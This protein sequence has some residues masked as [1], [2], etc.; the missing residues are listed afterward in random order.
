MK[1]LF[2][3]K[4]WSKSLSAE[5]VKW[6]GFLQDFV[7]FFRAKI[8]MKNAFF[9]VMLES[10]VFKILFW[11]LFIAGHIVWIKKRVNI[12]IF[13]VLLVLDCHIGSTFFSC[14]YFNQHTIRYNNFS[15]EIILWGIFI[16]IKYEKIGLQNYLCLNIITPTFEFHLARG[17]TGVACTRL[18]P[19]VCA[20]II[21]SEQFN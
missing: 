17:T 4:E 5:T 12:F 16:W 20:F 6:N 13:L 7:I 14:V 9:I 1:V 15:I 2:N 10:F 21:L 19:S 18:T 8:I 3:L 11:Q